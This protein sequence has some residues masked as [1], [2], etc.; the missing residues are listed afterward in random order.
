MWTNAVGSGRANHIL[1][2]VWRGF[3][4]GMMSYRF[5]RDIG[6]DHEVAEIAFKL[7]IS[8][9]TIVNRER[10]NI[11]DRMLAGIIIVEISLTLLLQPARSGFFFIH[12]VKWIFG[13]RARCDP[14]C[15]RLR[16]GRRQR[17]I[18]LVW[19]VHPLLRSCFTNTLCSPNIF[20]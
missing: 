4:R 1:F 14:K 8:G 10:R 7:D 16:S 18:K 9:V 5:G 20:K 19:L 13:K 2:I 15:F 3:R 12:K 6:M 17:L 11:L